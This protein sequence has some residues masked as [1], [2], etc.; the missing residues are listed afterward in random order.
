M[1][2]RQKIGQ[3][4]LCGFEGTEVTNELKRF[5]EEQQIG[6]VIYFA[7][8]VESAQQVARLTEQLQDIAVRSGNVPLWISIDQEGGMVARITEGITLMPGNMAVAAAG[9]LDSAYKLANLSGKELRELGINMNFAPVLDVNNNPGNPVIGVR[10]FGESAESAA[11]YGAR[12]VH[13]YQDAGVAATAKHFPGHGDTDVDSHLD[14]PTIA[15]SWDRV[16]RIEL[17]PFKRAIQEGVDAMMSAHI[18]FPA[19]E[20]KKLPATLSHAILTGLLRER[21]GYKGIIMTDCMEMNAIAEHYGTV[22]ASVMAIEAGAD[23]VLVSHTPELQ[24][25]AIEAIERAVQEG[26]ISEDRIN[27]S[28]TRVLALKAKRGILGIDGGTVDT[29]HVEVG[30]EEHMEAARRVS[31]ASIT[32]IRDEAKMLPLTRER[33]LVIT[34]APAVVT[35]VDETFKNAQSLGAALL[36]NGLDVV[37][38]VAKLADVPAELSALLD[39]AAAE[40][41]KQIVIGTYNAQ[42]SVAQISLVQGLQKVGKPL[43]VVALRNPYDLLVLPEVKTFVA[44]YESRPLTLRSTAKAL[45]GLI[46]FKGHLPVSLGDQY[47]VGWGVTNS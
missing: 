19:L 4:L 36:Q 42:F 1:N 24:I 47:P 32:L 35:M 21:L 10:S 3:M 41:V 9:S 20:T 26:Q 8:N 30:C 33:T 31:E 22:Q 2:L 28:V 39:E 23:I 25:G 45:L 7:R 40:D 29:Q 15:H 44:A 13:G 37:D 14:L 34:V 18:Y 38:R 43:A 12:M 17:V 5:I 11:E 6:G 46:P 27:A 16:E